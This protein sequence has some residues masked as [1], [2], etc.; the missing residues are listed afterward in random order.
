MLQ[1]SQENDFFMSFFYVALLPGACSFVM[2]M[3]LHIY[4]YMYVYI[5]IS[6]IYIYTYIYIYIWSYIWSYV[7]IH[8]CMYVY[9][10]V[11]IYTYVY[12]HTHTYMTSL[13][14]YY[15]SALPNTYARSWCGAADAVV[16]KAAFFPPIFG[17]KSG[18]PD[19]LSAAF[20]HFFLLLFPS[21]SSNS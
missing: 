9:V 21:E 10:F 15:S 18:Y 19:Y 6:Y 12:T 8:V 17:G 13:R 14:V 5:Y 3:T 1:A 7:C 11:C 20:L 16:P 2:Y 4:T